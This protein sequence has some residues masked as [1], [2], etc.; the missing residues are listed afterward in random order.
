MQSP[1]QPLGLFFSGLAVDGGPKA[2]P[3]WEWGGWADLVAWMRSNSRGVGVL[4]E[5]AAQR[6]IGGKTITGNCAVFPAF[7]L[8]IYHL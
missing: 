6:L 2:K 8:Y 5:E 7:Y 1:R 4:R 3:P